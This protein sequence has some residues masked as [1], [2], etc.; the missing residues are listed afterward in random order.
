MQVKRSQAMHR[1]INRLKKYFFVF[2]IFILPAGVVSCKS[3][4]GFKNQEQYEQ[5][6]AKESR[7]AERE[8]KK[9]RKAHMDNQSE[10]TK[11][12]MKATRRKAKE[13]NRF[14]RK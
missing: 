14:R 2:L 12:M 4:E 10:Q 5:K 3:S 6:K 11:A 13:I 9:L 7:K 1:K 8:L